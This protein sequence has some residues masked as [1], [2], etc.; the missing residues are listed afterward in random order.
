MPNWTEHIWNDRRDLKAAELLCA[1]AIADEADAMG[2]FSHGNE[3]LARK[4]RCTV[5]HLIGIIIRLERKKV[6]EVARGRGRGNRTTVRLLKKEDNFL[7][8]NAAASELVTGPAALEQ[9]AT[10]GAYY[11]SG[12]IAEETAEPHHSD[13]RINDRG[14]DLPV[15]KFSHR[16][17]GEMNID[18]PIKVRPDGRRMPILFRR[19]RR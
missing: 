9:D 5:R 7:P 18:R 6:L 11:N 13:P 10:R 2:S 17:T 3:W 19:R 16:P 12:A 14:V 8:P 1:L 15:P 4:L